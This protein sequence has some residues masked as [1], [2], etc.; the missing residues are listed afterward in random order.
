MIV[1]GLSYC[2]NSNCAKKLC[3]EFEIAF[4]VESLK[5][6]ELK[7]IQGDCLSK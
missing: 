2:R 6:R 1:I 3:K 7:Y 5:M 4:I